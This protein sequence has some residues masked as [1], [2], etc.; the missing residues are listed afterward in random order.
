[1]KRVPGFLALLTW[2]A[3]GGGGLP[4]DVSTCPADLTSCA[5]VCAN[6]TTD[7]HNCG[8][9]GKACPSGQV[10]GNGACV[11]ERCNDQ[12]GTV[13]DG[14]CVDIGSDPVNCG[15]CGKACPGGEVCFGGVCSGCQCQPPSICCNNACVD[16]FSDN[17]NCGACGMACNDGVVCSNGICRDGGGNTG[18]GCVKSIDCA[19][20]K[21]V[22]ITK[23]AMGNV[24]PGGYCTSVCNP[25]KNDP[26]DATNPACPGGMATCFGQGTQGACG[27]LCTDRHGAAPCLRMGY[28]CFQ[29]CQPTSLSQCDPTKPRACGMGKTCLRSGADDV[30]DCVPSCDIFVQVCPADMNGAMQTCLASLDTGEGGCVSPVGNPSGRDGDQCQALAGC[31]PGLG[32]YAPPNATMKSQVVCRPYC[33]G[34][35]NVGCS[36]GKQCVDCSTKVKK[37]VAGYCAG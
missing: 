13:C 4:N 2:T 17:A 16:T 3:C 21:P 36:N 6:L 10:C 15:A 32:C 23:D 8:R 37:A 30:G 24:W 35:K 5:G 19:G 34:P 28:S 1:M 14:K 18:D 7:I 25:Q 20:T 29:I 9:C 27:L 22:C 26:L 11:V 12:A 33:G 31:A